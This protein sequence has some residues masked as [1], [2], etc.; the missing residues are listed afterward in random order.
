ML[1]YAWWATEPRCEFCLHWGH[2][3]T[4]LSP[5]AGVC[6][7]KTV[8]IRGELVHRT[9]NHNARC[10]EFLR[11]PDLPKVITVRAQHDHS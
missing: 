9:V 10:D 4:S 8:L 6:K 2:R 11:R 3:P 1:E 7:R 5:L